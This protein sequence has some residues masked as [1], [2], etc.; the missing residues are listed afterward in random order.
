MFKNK[1]NVNSKFYLKCKKFNKKKPKFVSIELG[2]I[3]KR[4][5]NNND[6]KNFIDIGCA[7]G[8]LIDYLQSISN[9]I[10]FIGTDIENDFINLCKKN[11]VNASFYLDDLRYKP[12]KSLPLGDIIY[13]SGVHS[14]F[15]DPEIFLNGCIKRS[16]KGSKIIINGLFNPFDIDIL[17]KYKKSNDYN[18]KKKLVNQTGWNMFSIKTMKH[19]LYKNKKINNFKFIKINFPKSL[20][21]QKDRYN[22]IRSWTQNINDK[23]YFTNGLNMIQ[24]HY[25]LIINLK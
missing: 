20:K 16:N 25:F 7:N 3:L 2:K 1:T 12:N 4:E 8:A 5:L 24:H 22:R 21:V 13:L 17:I 18:L 14:H 6:V 9:N 15:D 19:L 11:I 23:N 10:N